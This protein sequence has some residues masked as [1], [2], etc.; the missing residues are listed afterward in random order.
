MAL[1]WPDRTNYKGEKG[2][3]PVVN[4]E[5]EQDMTRMSTLVSVGVARL[6]QVMTREA[7]VATRVVASNKSTDQV[8]QKTKPGPEVMSQVK[9]GI[10]A[11]VKFQPDKIRCQ[12]SGS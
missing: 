12:G 7:D 2:V 1:L 5:G 9:K 11:K 8:F 6:E 4:E 10:V 3:V